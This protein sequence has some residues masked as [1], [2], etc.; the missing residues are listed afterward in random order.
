MKF[1][2]IITLAL[3][4]ITAAVPTPGTKVRRTT[5]DVV[6]AQ[7]LPQISKAELLH[8]IQWNTSKQL[9]KRSMNKRDEF[10]CSGVDGHCGVG[11]DQG[12]QDTSNYLEG[13]QDCSVGGGPR[14]CIQ[15]TYMDGTGVWLCNDNDYPITIPCM[16]VASFII[17][18]REQ[19]GQAYGQEFENNF[20]VI[21]ANTEC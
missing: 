21:V 18:I 7:G 16:V 8:K 13:I 15:T 1:I 19:C 10:F 12:V 2:S 11:S 9:L 3:A 6:D 20:N 17:N 5:Q 14:N 4:T